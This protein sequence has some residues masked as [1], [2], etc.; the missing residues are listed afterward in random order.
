MCRRHSGS[1][2]GVA[3]SSY[4]AGGAF[5]LEGLYT[6]GELEDE[7]LSTGED[8]VCIKRRLPKKRVGENSYPHSVIPSYIM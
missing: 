1:R 3:V 8:G 5:L 6:C 7:L 2:G 4:G